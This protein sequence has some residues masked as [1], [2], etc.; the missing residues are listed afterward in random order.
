MCRV[1]NH[2]MSDL[3]SHLYHNRYSQPPSGDSRYPED[4]PPSVASSRP[5]RRGRRSEADDRHYGDGVVARRAP[6]H[7]LTRPPRVPSP[8]LSDVEEEYGFRDREPPRRRAQE[9]GKTD[10]PVFLAVGLAVVSLLL[11]FGGLE[12]SRRRRTREEREVAMEREGKGKEK[13]RGSWERE[14]VREKDYR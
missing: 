12:T 10:V 9:R 1:T 7:G 3:S 14:R 11:C 4:G 2:T 13:G 6:H 5:S 8:P